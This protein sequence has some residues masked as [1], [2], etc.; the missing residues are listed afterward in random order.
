MAFPPF[1]KRERK[2]CLLNATIG[3]EHFRE[4]GLFE[5]EILKQMT[6]QSWTCA[7]PKPHEEV[8]R[9]NDCSS[10]CVN[11]VP[12][13]RDSWKDGSAV[14]AMA[15]EQQPCFDLAASGRPLDQ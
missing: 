14:L 15:G 10:N 5:R 2:S 1:R 3:V 7:E 8:A 11:R 13:Q 4:R 12:E 6:T 9:D